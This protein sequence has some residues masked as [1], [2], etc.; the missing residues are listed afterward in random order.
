MT[1]EHES[2]EEY[3]ARRTAA[4]VK[5]YEALDEARDAVTELVLFAVKRAYGMPTDSLVV[6]DFDGFRHAMD[7]LEEAVHAY[8]P[9]EEWGE[10]WETR[11][12]WSDG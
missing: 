11:K 10:T 4:Q 2:N 1:E 7:R 8:E 3:W 5:T 12:S 6:F 9:V